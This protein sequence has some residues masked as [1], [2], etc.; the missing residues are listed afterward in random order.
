MNERY[1]Y[2]VA[3]NVIALSTGLGIGFQYGLSAGIAIGYII[4]VLVDIRNKLNP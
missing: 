2:Y 4:S 1:F 3:G